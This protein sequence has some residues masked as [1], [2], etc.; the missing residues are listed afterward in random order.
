VSAVV[1]AAFVLVTAGCGARAREDLERQ[2]AAETA[3]LTRATDSL[4]QDLEALRQDVAALRAEL[5]RAR[6]EIEGTNQ[7]ARIAQLQA[8]DALAK[9]IGTNQR[10]LD[11]L[12]STVGGVETTLDG[13]ADQ[14]ARLEAV[15]APMPQSRLAAGTTG[16]G[17]PTAP[18]GPEE[19]FDRAMGSF[20]GGELGQAV[21][22]FEEFVSKNP[23]H[24]LV[25]NAEFWIGEAYFRARDFD[26]AASAYQKTV[27]L[28][29]KGDRTADA[30]L[31]LG[32]ALRALKHEDQARE[33]WSRLVRDF[34]DSE[35]SKRAKTL[36]RESTT[37][38]PPGATEPAKPSS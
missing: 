18:I 14:V 34:P 29:P 24:P 15:S 38:A 23:K 37:P 13:L 2:R 8:V 9:Q 26:N 25:A 19:L 31:R 6:K 4:R 33:A 36:L 20:R 12:A 35:A 5:D 21:L 10:R 22:D 27:T 11:D 3:E 32:L 16:P 17:S 30:L 1:A 7:T 28:A